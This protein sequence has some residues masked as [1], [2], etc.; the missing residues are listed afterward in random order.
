MFTGSAEWPDAK[1]SRACCAH[2]ER[3][4]SP[5]HPVLSVDANKLY[6][7]VSVAHELV[8]VASVRAVVRRKRTVRRPH[9]HA[10]DRIQKARAA[11]DTEATERLV[12]KNRSRRTLASCAT[13]SASRRPACTPTP[14]T[15]G[16]VRIKVLAHLAPYGCYGKLLLGRRPSDLKSN[17]CGISSGKYVVSREQILLRCNLIKM[18]YTRIPDRRRM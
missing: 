3:K 5:H 14:A 8:V 2:P 6:K 13:I 15:Y 7:T 1:I 18:K 4:A 17:H 16:L 12:V 11:V 10:V 9:S